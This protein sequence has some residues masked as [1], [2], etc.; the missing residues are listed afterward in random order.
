MS[1]RFLADIETG[2]ANPSVLRLERVATALETS[3]AELLSGLAAAF[4]AGGPRVVIALLGLRGAGKSTIGRALAERLG[5]PFYELD[6]DVER[7]MGLP[8]TEIFE[9]HGEAGYRRVE[10][11]VLRERLDTGEPCVL[12]TGGGIV[13]DAETWD[14]LRARAR[15]VWLRAEAQDHWDRVVAQ[16]D[17][18]P[19]AGDA[20]AFANLQAIL[21]SRVELYGNAQL[22]A[23][24]SGRDIKSVLAELVANLRPEA[25]AP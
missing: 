19:M 3:G 22:S 11:E 5:V 13:T 17:M 14:L 8:L 15:T 24:T 23:D 10:R 18:R 12:A 21:A 6:E 1:E 20:R 4:S 9:V 2:K 7:R 16:G 25:P